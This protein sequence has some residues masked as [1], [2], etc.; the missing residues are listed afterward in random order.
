MS[1]T[2]EFDGVGPRE[3]R[4][5]IP[6]ISALRKQLESEPLM[7]CGYSSAATEA[8]LA[9]NQQTFGTESFVKR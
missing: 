1:N 9:E 7:L 6:I 3:T 2:S 4:L 5:A 8:Q